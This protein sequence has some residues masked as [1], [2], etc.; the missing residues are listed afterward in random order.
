LGSLQG[1][2]IAVL[3]LAFKPGTDDLRESVALKVIQLLSARGASVRAYD[4]IAGPALMGSGKDIG[5]SVCVSPDEALREADAA[6]ITTACPEFAEWN[7]ANLCSIMRRPV[8]IDG[9]NA[10]H[11]I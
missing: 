11:N 6:L 3:G 1:T 9:R 10:F 4:A 2:N 7:W 5:A 8:I